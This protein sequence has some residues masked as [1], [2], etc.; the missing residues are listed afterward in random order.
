MAGVIPKPLRFEITRLGLVQRLAQHLDYKL[1]ALIAP[2]GYG[3]ST[4]LAQYARAAERPV[5]WVNLNDRPIGAFD[6]LAKLIDA[7]GQIPGLEQV[8]HRMQT[9][10]EQPSELLTNTLLTALSDLNINVDL[11]FDGIE[12]LNADA[13]KWLDGLIRLLGEG[14]RVILSGYS[15]TQLN[16][17][18]LAA[19]DEMLVLD[20]KQLSFSQTEIESY[21]N[22]RGV[23]Q[24]HEAQEFQSLHGWPAGLALAASGITTHLK[25]RDLVREAVFSLPMEIQQYLPEVAVLEVWSEASAREHGLQLHEGWLDVVIRSGLPLSPLQRGIY[26][27]HRLL[28]EHLESELQ[29]QPKHFQNLMLRAAELAQ[30]RSELTLALRLFIKAQAFMQALE[31]VTPLVSQYRVRGERRSI[32]ELLELFPFEKLSNELQCRLAFNW[33]ET[34]EPERGERTL[35]QLADSGQIHSVGLASLAV[36]AHRRGDYPEQLRLA[37]E[38]RKIQTPNEPPGAVASQVINALLGLGRLEEA[39]NEAQVFVGWAEVH[40]DAGQLVTALSFLSYVLEQQHQFEAQ[41]LT[42]LRTIQICQDQNLPNRAAIL[43]IDLAK[44]EAMRGEFGVA[45]ELL[46]IARVSIEPTDSFAIAFLEE[47]CGLAADWAGVPDQAQQYFERGLRTAE[48]ARANVLTQRLYFYLADLSFRL[49]KP[50]ANVKLNGHYLGFMQALKNYQ[51]GQFETA[52]TQLEMLEYLPLE[53]HLAVRVMAMQAD[54]LEHLGRDGSAIRSKFVGWDSVVGRKILEFEQIEHIPKKPL[55]Q[56]L[57]SLPTLEPAKPEMILTTLG[58][59]RAQINGVRV[60]IHLTKSAELLA[61]LAIH[62]SGTREVIV[63]A[64]WGTNAEERHYEYFRVAVRRLRVALSAA[65]SGLVNPL[66]IELGRYQLAAELKIQTDLPSESEA[67]AALE[68]LEA[69]FIRLSQPFLPESEAEWIELLRD[70]ICERAVDLGLRLAQ[71]QTRAT[72]AIVRY[73]QVLKLDPMCDKANQGLIEQHYQTGAVS[74]AQKALE[75]YERVLRR[76]LG[77]TPME[78]FLEQMRVWGLKPQT[79]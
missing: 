11:L 58:E 37:L 65:Y 27:P 39:L 8:Q 20:I 68:V 50:Q 71:T 24:R 76:E 75:Q 9:R 79:L 61:W 73:Q 59:F 38:A 13:L 31:V 54:C 26:Q 33:I 66:P 35:N 1:I 48:T 67:D 41:R 23:Y 72:E 45:E 57:D 15:L 7:L 12:T 53:P 46:R 18:W 69:E 32:R 49:G 5:A 40:Q 52:L 4:L 30:A 78:S 21:F 29:L 55:V 77:L 14:H 74:A 16:L 56:A 51:M 28:L 6:V 47:G 17:A 36:L 43:Q 64:L 44:L 25:P 62:R 19:R 3:K 2:S 60:P 10:Q 63:E 34:G 22:A 42:L 70:Q